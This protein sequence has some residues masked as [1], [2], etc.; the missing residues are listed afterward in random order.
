[1]N[2]SFV[3]RV[4]LLLALFPFISSSFNGALAGQLSINGAVGGV[5][6]V[7]G[8]SEEF[9][10]F[11]EVKAKADGQAQRSLR[12]P[13]TGKRNIRPV[14]M[15][16]DANL[17]DQT[18][19]GATAGARARAD[20]GAITLTLGGVSVMTMGGVGNLRANAEPGITFRVEPGGVFVDIEEASSSSTINFDPVLDFFDLDEDGL[21]NDA[22]V[23][24]LVGI[25]SVDPI[26]DNFDTEIESGSLFSDANVQGNFFTGNVYTI[27]SEISGLNIPT[28]SVKI[29][30]EWEIFDVFSG[31]PLTLSQFASDWN[32]YITTPNGTGF[33]GQSPFGASFVFKDVSDDQLNDQS[34][35]DAQLSVE[36][37][38]SVPEPSFILSLLFLSV[39]T[40]GLKLIHK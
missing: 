24:F 10:G 11:G 7:F 38:A 12:D 21:E 33:G 35:W 5:N 29:S 18:V 22:I 25:N 15:S 9:N 39:G 28:S 16:I 19:K 26:F 8:F 34:F 17:P 4:S 40:F 2:N 6:R 20:L 37:I 14:G 30:P 1:M 36:A 13:L 27:E 3:L 32:D 23:I 31:L